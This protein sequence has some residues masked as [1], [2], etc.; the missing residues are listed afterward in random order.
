MLF[1]L[2][3]RGRRRTV[4]VIY[5]GLALLIGGG[6][7]GFGVGAGN[8][9]G[10]I[11]NAFTGGG[12]GGAQKAVISQEEKNALAAT[13]ANPNNA[14]AWGQL[15]QARWTT[16]GQSPDFNANTG[17]F[18]TA[19]KQE[20]AGAVSAW[21]RYVALAPSPDPNLAVLAARAY[22][23]LGNYSGAASAWEH[24]TLVSPT[25]AK[26]YECLAVTAYAAGQS[27]KGDLAS[28]KAIT[29]LPK[30]QQL[31]AKQTLNSAKSSK[32][33]AQQVAQQC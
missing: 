21:E 24:E 27:R 22:V 8:G 17:A 1:D 10:G 11:L 26:G 15:L 9:V 12:S 3:S 16:A 31:T 30:A 4:Q 13:R 7:V 2:R 29:L 19:G 23:A 18:T 6:L 5:L 33:S 20:L 25:E 32:S 14:A 28:A